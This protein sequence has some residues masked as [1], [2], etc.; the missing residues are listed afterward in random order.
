MTNWEVV[1]KI[2]ENTTFGFCVNYE[3]RY[4]DC[5]ECDNSIYETSWND[6]SITCP[7]CGKRWEQ[8]E[9]SI[10]KSYFAFM[11]S[12]PKLEDFV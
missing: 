7:I 11:R 1:A 5:P 6:V 4:F 9:Q 12:L 10:L 8:A 2:L 3:K